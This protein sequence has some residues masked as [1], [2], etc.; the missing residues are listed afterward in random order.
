MNA[1]WSP[2]LLKMVANLKLMM[3][4][5]VVI[6]CS[7]ALLPYVNG[8]AIRYEEQGKLEKRT[9]EVVPGSASIGMEKRSPTP[10]HV[11]STETIKN[12][13]LPK[14]SLQRQM[15]KEKAHFSMP[16]IHKRE[17]VEQKEKVSFVARS[18][19]SDSNKTYS[20]IADKE[21]E[22]MDDSRNTIV[23]QYAKHHM[24]LKDKVFIKRDPIPEPTHYLMP[25]LLRP[26]PE[27]VRSP[28]REEIIIASVDPTFPSEARMRLNKGKQQ[29][30]LSGDPMIVKKRFY[31]AKNEKGAHNSESW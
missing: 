1:S 8:V 24:L 23:P 21:P 27:Y 2:L 25:H 9:N 20:L 31:I 17:Q 16:F 30:I 5:I 13:D 3:A 7:S 22:V 4:L 10:G 28:L 14:D 26:E 11:V 15:P 6:A 12:K 29:L 19:V 18:P